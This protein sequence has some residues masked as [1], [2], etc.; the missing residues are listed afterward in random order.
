M[1]TQED[2]DRATLM[3]GRGEVS[4]SGREGAVRQLEDAFCAR[5]GFRYALASSSGTAALHS[6]FFG[7]GLSA[8]DEIIAPSYTFLST[9]MP[10]FVCNA[11]PILADSDPETGNID[12]GD[13]ERRITRRTKAIVVTHLAGH[14]VDIEP[15]VAIARSRG[16]ALVEDCAQA[17]GATAGGRNVGSFGDVAIFSFERKKLVV[18]GEGGV[19][20]TDNQ[21][22]YERATLLGHFR[23]RSQEEVVSERYRDYASTGFGLNYRMHPISAQL[24]A[25]Q[26]ARLDAFLDARHENLTRLSE[27]LD[28]TP[29]IQPPV[30]QRHVTRHAHYGYLPLYDASALGGL[31]IDTYVAAVRAEGVPLERPRGLPLHME[32]VFQREERALLTCPNVQRRTYRNGDFPVSEAY[33]ARVLRLPPYTDR[34]IQPWFQGFAE[35]FAKVAR[36]AE[37]LSAQTR[38]W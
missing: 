35:A 20:V 16:L 12:P 25:G 33:C 5:F 38:Q 31:D 21:E 29:G 32:A 13:I 8:G 1:L 2:V 22:I 3:L 15:I 30:T 34:S 24:A 37:E 14:P 9:V 27:S 23:E 18:G 11:V 6:A 26:L 36:Y 28:G 10:A 19:L 4:Y 7:I 17:H